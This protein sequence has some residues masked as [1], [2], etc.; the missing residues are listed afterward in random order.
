MDK[1]LAVISQKKKPVNKQTPSK[2][3]ERAQHL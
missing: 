2:Y 3:V 1:T